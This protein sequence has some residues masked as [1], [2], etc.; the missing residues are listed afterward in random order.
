MLVHTMVPPLFTTNADGD[1][2]QVRMTDTRARL[3]RKPRKRVLTFTRV[4]HGLPEHARKVADLLTTHYSKR[5]ARPVQLRLLVR[6]APIQ[7]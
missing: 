3:W 7:S 4:F 2:V 5:H 1:T 6:P